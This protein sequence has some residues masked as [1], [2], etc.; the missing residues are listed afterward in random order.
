MRCKEVKPFAQSPTASGR[1]PCVTQGSLP[2]VLGLCC[3]HKIW[4]IKSELHSILILRHFTSINKGLLMGLVIF[5]KKDK[6]TP[7][8]GPCLLLNHGKQ[9]SVVIYWAASESQALRRV[10]C[11]VQMGRSD[12]K[13]PQVTPELLREVLSSRVGFGVAPS[14]AWGNLLA[15]V[16]SPLA[17]GRQFI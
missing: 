4:R 17:F 1:V 14:W 5:M 3:C 16:Q 6:S 10:L 9:P 15:C 2:C 12:K 7:L 13:L 11:G 8:C